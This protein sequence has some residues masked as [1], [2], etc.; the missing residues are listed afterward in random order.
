[1]G[2][3][4]LCGAGNTADV[5]LFFIDPPA[6]G[7]GIGRNLW[8][9]LIGQA[10]NAGAMRITIEADP[11]AE[12]FYARMGAIRNGSVPSAS[13]PGRHLPLLVYALD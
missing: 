9:H 4:Q 8:A 1:M 12:G 13:I 10:K 5:A 6:I 3:Y 11:D 7:S 2:F